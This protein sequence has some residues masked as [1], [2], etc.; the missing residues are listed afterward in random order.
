VRDNVS[1]PYKT[2]GKNIILYILI[3]KI[4]GSK[5]EHKKNLHQMIASVAWLQYDFNFCTEFL[6][7]FFPNIWKPSPFQ[8]FYY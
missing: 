4:L 1:H 2:T 7:G 3:F 5:L 6:L 8:T